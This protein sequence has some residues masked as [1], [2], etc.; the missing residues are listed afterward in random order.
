MRYKNCGV[1]W[2]KSGFVMAL[3]SHKNFT[4][5]EGRALSIRR[6]L[7]EGGREGEISKRKKGSPGKDF[8]DLV[9]KNCSH[10][11]KESR[12]RIFRGG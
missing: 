8:T 2:K 1:H 9:C 4:D 5:L 7:R 12:D 10:K 11:Q 6:K 3:Q